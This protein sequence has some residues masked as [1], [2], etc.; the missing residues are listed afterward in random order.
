MKQ[1]DQ[2]FLSSLLSFAEVMFWFLAL[3]PRTGRPIACRLPLYAPISFNRLMFSCTIFLASFSIV[4][5]DSSAVSASTVFDDKDSSLARGKIEY[6]AMIRS[7]VVGPR[8]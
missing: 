3:C 8:A 1:P 4:I 7:A 5:V 2:P 6:L